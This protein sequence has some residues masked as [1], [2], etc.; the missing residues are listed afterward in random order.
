MRSAT[1]IAALVGIHPPT[2]EQQAII[3]APLDPMLVVAGAGSGKTET[4]AAR[5]VYLVAN[6]LVE[7]DR[8][9]GLTFTRK[10]AGELSDRIR[11]RLRA[12]QRATGGRS[13]GFHAPTVSTYNSYAASLV[14][15]HAVRIGVEPSARLL[16]EAGRWQIAHDV[17]EHW[18]GDLDTALKVPTVTTAV[19]D[20]AGEIAEHLADPGEVRAVLTNAIEAMAD[21]PAVRK[22]RAPATK[23][24]LEAARSMEL[25]TRLVD[26]V[27]E[28]TAR[29][30]AQDVI[31][32]ADQVAL[33]ARVAREMPEVGAGERSRFG[34]VLLDEY[35][36]TS[37]AQLVLLRHLFG[38]DSG[39]PGHPVTAVGDPH[40][41]IYGW[42]GASSG[43]LE[44]FPHDFHLG[45]GQVLSD[46]RGGNT[47]ARVLALSTSWRNDH[48]VLDVANAVA[49][50]LRAAV[51]A[52]REPGA[53]S[54]PVLGARPTAGAGVVEARF[55]ESHE[56]EARAV[57]EFIVEQ[58]VLLAAERTGPV[59]SAVLCRTRAQFGVLEE[60]LLAVGLQVEVAGL[61]GLL[62][63]PEVVDVV[64]ALE[65]AH[66]PS[67]GDSLMR[68]L[69][70]PRAR[71]GL[72]DLAALSDW[73]RELAGDGHQSDAA[74]RSDLPSIVDALDLLPAPGWTSPQGRSLS[75]AGRARLADLAGMLR[76]LRSQTFLPVADLVVEA[77]RL[78]GLDI[79]VAVGRDAP[80]LA[81]AHLDAFRAVAAGFDREDAGTLGSFLAWLVA[82]RT[83]E[84]GLAAPPAEADPDAVQIMTVHAAKG[85]EWDVVAVPGLVEGVFPSRLDAKGW[86]RSNGAIP[87]SL[88]GDRDHLPDVD[89]A[90][91]GERADLAERIEDYGSAVREHELAEERRLA[92]VA[93]T[94]ACSRLLLTGSW[95]RTGT[96]PRVPSCFLVELIEQGVVTL[97]LP[98]GPAGPRPEPDAGLDVSWPPQ[99]PLGAERSARV[100]R[101]ARAVREATA[102]ADWGP[103]DADGRQLATTAALLLAERRRGREDRTTVLMP[104]HL[105]ASALVRLAADP[106]EYALAVRR[107][108]PQAPSTVARRGTAFH[109][110]VEQYYGAAS[111]VDLDELPGADDESIVED[112]DL[113]TLRSAFLATPWADRTPIA[114][115][116]DIETSIG[117][118]TLRSRIDAVFAEPDGGVVVVDWKTGRPPTGAA[119]ARARELQLAVYRV[120]W[121][122]RSGM[123]L[124]QVDAAF[125]Y[126]GSSETV[127]PTVLPGLAEIE[128]ALHDGTAPGGEPQAA[129]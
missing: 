30:R 117:G 23:L 19:L 112:A 110:W 67:R 14:A 61:G 68:L 2:P 95:W 53:P 46:S 35:Q 129:D 85:L 78:L 121:A 28:F 79:E 55:L 102:S 11:A 4:M 60:A 84:R 37:V 128:R 27:E 36:D 1:E 88:R 66:D 106:A 18:A 22:L 104:A 5:V 31:D 94:R 124:D 3:E 91:E 98:D 82:A 111:L 24:L 29:K 10:A 93:V 47:H 77:E 43:G 38:A 127:R 100:V 41:S 56:D 50:P 87:V 69:T 90:A 17:V 52:R 80:A 42:R 13:I 74:D 33:A 51:D 105:S 21:A 92:Y 119:A 65:A 71:L 96:R 75:A 32:F 12:L 122:R 107:P 44:Q 83:E 115:E 123:P 116:V 48:A 25:R 45:T 97:D 101:S 114:V 6:E 126:V 120:A 26:M 34:V 89:L 64:A 58:R 9:L 81:R 103:D 62:D 76:T 15:D 20:L 109:A 8:V 113:A 125:V 49:A 108:V 16:G 70:G 63:S 7:P 54:L 73:A 40:Q 39:E 57:A 86:V 118:F 99:S 59:T 72:A